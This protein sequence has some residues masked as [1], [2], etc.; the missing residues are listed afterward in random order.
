MI[1]CNV[2]FSWRSWAWL[3]FF[4]VL[5]I[6]AEHQLTQSLWDEPVIVLEI[7]GTYESML[8]QSTASFSPLIRGHIWAGIPKTDARLRFVDSQYGFDTPLARF[9][10]V[11]FNDNLVDDIRM[12]PQIEPLL[13]DDAM[14]VVLDLQAQWCAK[15]WRP[16]GTRRNP[17]ISDTPEWRAYLRNGELAGYSYWQAGDKYQ[18]MLIL[19][20][21][22]DYRYPDQERYLITLA[23]AAPW[24]QFEEDESRFEPHHSPPPQPKEGTQSCQAFAVSAQFIA[25]DSVMEGGG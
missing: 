17:T 14:K 6:A 21:F 13:I 9:L 1:S 25:E 24:L 3:V 16:I 18:A 15:G 19:G 7:G 2:L 12:S 4:A 23:I 5:A 8:E 22:N 10:S 20:R 11:G